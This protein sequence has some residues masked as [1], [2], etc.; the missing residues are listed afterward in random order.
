MFDIPYSYSFRLPGEQVLKEKFNKTM[1][2]KKREE[3]SAHR[4]F[5]LCRYCLQIITSSDAC[6]KIFGTHQHTFANPHGFVYH[7]GC[8]KSADGC[9]HV[10]TFSEE[11][12]WFAGFCWKI[13][14]CKSCLTHLG[15]LFSSIEKGIFY[16][17]ILD[18]IIE[19]E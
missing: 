9:R 4:E 1:E 3:E 14:V 15:W 18:K 7:I 5:L 17:L 19:S 16:G 8:F 13:A 11:W 2:D 10:G 12:S 6:V